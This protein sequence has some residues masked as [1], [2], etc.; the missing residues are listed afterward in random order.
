[1]AHKLTLDNIDLSRKNNFNV[2]SVENEYDKAMRESSEMRPWQEL[3]ANLNRQEWGQAQ[4]T[5]DR[6][7][8]AEKEEARAAF[9]GLP[10]GRF[11]LACI[12]VMGF[13]F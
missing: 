5:W 12:K 4:N 7:T 3:L 10:C 13:E 8:T 2:T 11:T 1:M 6:F 9:S